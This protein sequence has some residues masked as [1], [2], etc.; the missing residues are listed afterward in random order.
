MRHGV[1]ADDKL[2]RLRAT[3]EPAAHALSAFL[4]MPLPPWMPPPGTDD[5][6]SSDAEK[7]FEEEGATDVSLL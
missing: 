2:K 6:P 4:L 5:K 1:E 7:L 3:Y